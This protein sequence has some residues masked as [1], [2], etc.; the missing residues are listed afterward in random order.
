MAKVG[1]S[2]FS[3]MVNSI[4]NDGKQHIAVYRKNTTSAT[5]IGVWFDLSMLGGFPRPNFYVGAQFESTHYNSNYALYT[6]PTPSATSKKFL[7]KWSAMCG[8]NTVSTYLLDYLMFYPLIDGDDT[9]Q[10]DLINLVSLPRYSD[11]VGVRAMAVFTGAHVGNVDCTISYTNE[12]GTPG[13]IV[14]TRFSNSGISS[15]LATGASV[16]KNCNAPFFPLVSGDLGVRSVESVTMGGSAGGLICIVLVKPIAHMG[17]LEAVTPREVDLFI[18][19][20]IMPEIQDGACLN[21]IG[22]SP[23]SIANQSFMGQVDLIWS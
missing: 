16:L 1:F 21:F 12:L 3:K 13:Q 18:E 11:G 10:Q 2:N 14:T 17:T 20:S 7:H 8:V 6:G 23:S 4:V 15:A 5:P 19:K 9:A 22:L